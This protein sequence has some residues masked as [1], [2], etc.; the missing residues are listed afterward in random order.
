MPMNY[1]NRG[2]IVGLIVNVAQMCEFAASR[3][4]REVRKKPSAHVDVSVGETTMG[5]EQ[6]DVFV[7]EWEVT[8]VFWHLCIWHVSDT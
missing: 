8:A 7:I 4:V 1:H 2:I 3:D 6:R 5:R